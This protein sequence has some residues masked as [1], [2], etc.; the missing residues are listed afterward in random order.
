MNGDLNFNVVFS[1][2]YC[3][4]RCLAGPNP[5]YDFYIMLTFHFLIEQRHGLVEGF[6]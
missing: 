6:L 5:L 3:F 2:L 4:K 1:C